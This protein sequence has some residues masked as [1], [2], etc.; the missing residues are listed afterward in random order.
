MFWV[1]KIAAPF[2]MPISLSFIFSLI[3]LLLLWFTK[4]QKTAKIFIFVGIIV[5]ILPSYGFFSD[6]LLKPLEKHYPPLM[7]SNNHSSVPKKLT[8][9]QWIVVLGGGCTTDHTVPAISQLTHESFAR[10]M[11]GIRLHRKIPGSKLILSGGTI[12][13][14]DSL[15][16][17]ETM[18]QVARIYGI[19]G[20][21][22]ALEK[23]SRDTKEQAKNIKAIVGSKRFLLVTSAYHMPRAMAIFKKRE[24]SPIPAPTDY[25]VKQKN[26]YTIEDFYPRAEN[27]F[28]AERAIHE[29]LGI[30]WYRLRNEL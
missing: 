10:I 25:L 22:M 13:P 11:E 12:Y 26:Y 17:A 3:G 7:I 14:L 15:T 23:K 2:L 19:Q 6:A 18:A 16:E 21:D 30:F 24:M 27:L 20:K 9:I 8:A 5:I 1:K 28:K 4:K 29:Y